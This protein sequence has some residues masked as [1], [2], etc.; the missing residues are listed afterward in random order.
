MRVRSQ[1]L[2]CR[3]AVELV[4]AYIEGTLSRRDHRRLER[5]LAQCE[6]CSAYLEQVL[7]TIAAAGVAEP[8]DLDPD[9]LEGLVDLFEKFRNEELGP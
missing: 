5:H 9:V 4:S 7:A 2:V 3:E 6:A 8:D 1:P